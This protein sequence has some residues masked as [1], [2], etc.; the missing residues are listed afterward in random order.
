MNVNQVLKSASAASLTA[1]AILAFVAPS[2]SFAETKQG[3]SYVERMSRLDREFEMNKKEKLVQKQREE[4]A[5][6]QAAY[7]NITNKGK[8]EAELKREIEK[9]NRKIEEEA[10]IKAALSS[11]KVIRTYRIGKSSEWEALIITDAGERP[12]RKNT[13]IPNVG[14][15]ENIDI[16]GIQMKATKA[17]YDSGRVMLPVLKKRTIDTASNTSQNDGGNNPLPIA[18][19]F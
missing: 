14:K 15:V 9:R 4:I 13:V 18:P 11:I 5:R 2:C 10:R 8:D 3:E 12:V 16:S 1:I 17:G 19:S 7:H 6:S